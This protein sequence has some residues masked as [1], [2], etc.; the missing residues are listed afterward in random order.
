MGKADNPMAVVDSKA[1]VFGVI[2]LRVLD[3]SVFPFALPSHPTATLYALAEKIAEDIKQRDM[4]P[5][6]LAPLVGH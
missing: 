2:G 5:G 1:R 6:N 4:E 3:A